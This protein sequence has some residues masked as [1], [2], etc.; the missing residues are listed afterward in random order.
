MEGHSIVDS[1]LHDAI[2]GQYGEWDLTILDSSRYKFEKFAGELPGLLQIDESQSNE[3]VLHIQGNIYGVE[4]ETDVTFTI[5]AVDRE[6]GEDVFQ[7]LTIHVRHFSPE[8]IRSL[9]WSS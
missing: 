7:D 1:N 6:T 8:E 9:W 3:Y 2:I 5:S 4:N